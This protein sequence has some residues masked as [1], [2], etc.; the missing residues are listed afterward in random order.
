MFP[1]VREEFPVRFLKVRSIEILQLL[2]LFN[3]RCGRKTGRGR[4]R[5]LLEKEGFLFSVS[6]I[7]HLYF[8]RQ[9]GNDVRIW[10]G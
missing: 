9:D 2:Y 5:G 10:Q 7:L 1:A 4:F 8:V 3:R 6:V